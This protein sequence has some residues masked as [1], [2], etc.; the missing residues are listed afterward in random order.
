MSDILENYIYTPATTDVTIRWR[1]MY[2]WTPPSE[3]PV[4]QK[5]W[6]DF[7]LMAARGVES[8]TAPMPDPVVSTLI[9]WRQR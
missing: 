3:D 5:K 2:G 8:I 7:R 9:K 1:K 4:Y 6:A